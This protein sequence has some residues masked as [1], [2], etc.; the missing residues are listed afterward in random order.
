MDSNTRDELIATLGEVSEEITRINQ[1]AG[2]TVFN[3][4]VTGMVRT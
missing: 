3:P 4:T 1:A 2:H